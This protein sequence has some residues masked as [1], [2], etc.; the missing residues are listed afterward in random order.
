M[1]DPA[2]SLANAE[3]SDLARA[4]MQSL[5]DLKARDIVSINLKGNSSV[6]DYMLV[7]TGT[8]NRHV[9]AIADRLI[10]GMYARGLHGIKSCGQAEGEWVVVDLGGV[11]VHVL[12]PEARE[13]YQLEDLYRC[14]AAGEQSEILEAS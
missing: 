11:M 14:M 1:T 4:A 2:L 5:E 9:S 6:A 8:S 13:R 12:Q 7:A 10:D 3:P